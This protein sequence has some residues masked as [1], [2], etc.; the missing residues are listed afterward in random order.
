MPLLPDALALGRERETVTEAA[1]S[2]AR[3]SINQRLDTLVFTRPKEKDCAR[4]NKRRVKHRFDL[5]LFLE[6]SDVPPDNNLGERDIR[7]VAAT[8]AD[9]GVNR[10][11]SGAE[12]FAKLRCIART[13]RKHGRNFIDYAPSLIGL[14]EKQQPLPFAVTATPALNTS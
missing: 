7:S 3:T 11:K 8:R 9:G 10:T 13:C 6:R 12:A 2:A 14:D 4:I 5:L 1:F